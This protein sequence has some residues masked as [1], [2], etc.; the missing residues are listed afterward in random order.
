MTLLTT[1]ELSQRWK[2]HSKSLSNWRVKNI[3][4]AYIQLGEG[5]NAK[6]LYRIEDVVAF[7]TGRIVGEAVDLR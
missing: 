6:V 2:L 4:P 3:G 1:E 5:K 7:E